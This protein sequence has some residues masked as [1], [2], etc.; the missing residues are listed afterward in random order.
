M[1]STSRELVYN[2]L[3]FETPQRIPR[4][5]WL[6]PWATNHYPKQV[7]MIKQRFPSDFVLPPDVYHQSTVRQGDPYVL[8]TYIDEWGCEFT[9]IQAG[10]HG[11]VRHPL[12]TDLAEWQKVRPPYETLPDNEQNARD[13]INQFCAAT[14]K[15]VFWGSCPRPWERYQF[16][17]GSVNAYMDIARQNENFNSLLRKVHEYYLKELEFWCNTDVDALTF[18]DDWGSQNRLLISPRMWREIFKPLYR[19]YCDLA[20]I[21]GKFIFMHSDGH[22]L[23]IYPDLIEIGVDAI[24]S[25]LFCMDMHQVAECAKGKITFWGE[26]DRQH[27]LPASPEKGREA[28]RQVA[29]HLYDPRGGIIAQL[30]FGP[31]GNP[32]TVM[33]VYEEWENMIEKQIITKGRL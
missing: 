17:R 21:H 12:L 1:A 32:N 28:V 27:V 10:V 14:D 18:M 25:Q 31:G 23:D 9:N 22:I 7:E 24:N 30:E 11:E 26:I 2:C 13:Q 29:Q 19:D 16:I 15:F 3:K 4:D 20:H 33:A 5:F 8:G 6:L